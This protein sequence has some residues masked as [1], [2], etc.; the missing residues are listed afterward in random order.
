MS[1]Q[2]LRSGYECPSSKLL[3]ILH[4]EEEVKMADD[5]TQ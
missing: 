2:K 5:Y 1:S 3:G 4:G